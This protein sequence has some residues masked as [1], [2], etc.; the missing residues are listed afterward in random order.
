MAKFKNAFLDEYDLDWQKKL[1]KVI[2]NNPQFAEQISEILDFN[3]FSVDIY[4]TVLKAYYSYR[5]KYKNYP[6]IDLLIS[7]IDAEDKEGTSWTR[8]KNFLISVKVDPLV[9]EEEFI[10][11][12]AIQF[13]RKK[14]VTMAVVAAADIVAK[15]SDEGSYEEILKLVTDAVNSG[16]TNSVGHRYVEDFA[17]RYSETLRRSIPTGITQLDAITKGGLGRGEIGLVIAGTGGGKSM[18]M[19]FVAANAVMAGYK[20]I[21]YSLELEDHYIGLRFDSAITGIPLDDLKDNQEDVFKAIEQYKDK[22]IVKRYPTKQCTLQMMRSHIEKQKR[23]GFHPDLIVVDYADLMKFNS[24]YAELRH[25]L[26]NI[27]EELRGF[28]AEFSVAMWTASQTNKEGYK[29]TTPGLEHTSEAFSK[30]FCTDL[31]ITIGRTDR[32]KQAHTAVYKIAKNRNGIDGITYVGK[33]DT[34]AV[35]LSFDRELDDSY[36]EEKEKWFEQNED[37]AKQEIVKKFII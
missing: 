28:A 8:I 30:A 34:R 17:V 6:T 32:E 29:S 10:K 14:K 23:M 3:Y 22:L 9:E 1:V 21:Y 37:Q 19:T 27:V 2:L 33:M 11:D 18:F 20:V 7:I 31:S 36:E 35:Q 16:A 24:Q 15:K 25:N 26:Q 13:C 12:S 4:K 5:E